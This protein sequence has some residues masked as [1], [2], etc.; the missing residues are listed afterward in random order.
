MRAASCSSP[1]SFGL[2]LPGDRLLACV[3]PDAGLRFRPSLPSAFLQAGGASPSTPDS[4]ERRISD[5][6]KWPGSSGNCSSICAAP[7]SCYGIEGQFTKAVR[8]KSSCAG[9]RV[10]AR[11]FSPAMPRNLTPMSSSGTISSEPWPTARRMIRL[12]S[13]GSFIRRFKDCGNPKNCSGLASTHQTFHGHRVSIT[14][15]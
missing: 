6:R 4:I 7:W 9:T 11:T 5:L 2:G 3:A 13:S 10:C 8:S 12:I 14:Y 1:T 15:A